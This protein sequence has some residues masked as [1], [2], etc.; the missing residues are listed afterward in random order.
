MYDYFLGG[1]HNFAIDREAAARVLAAEPDFAHFVRANREFLRRAVSF[2]V[3]SGV[4]QLLDL[5]SGIP[6]VGNV[7][8]VAQARDPSIRVVYV[9]IDPIAYSLSREILGDNPNAVAVHADAMDPEELLSLPD[10]QRMLDLRQPVAVLLVAFLHFVDDDKKASGLIGYLRDVLAPGS[11]LALTHATGVFNP[12]R[13]AN[14][15]TVY[16]RATSAVTLRSREQIAAF[17]EGFELVE[18]GIVPTPAWRPDARDATF[19]NEP[20]RGQA[21]AGVGR[22]RD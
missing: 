12:E 15:Q 5:G 8:E 13:A 21:F 9:D 3:G 16:N 1:Y 19:A 6:T 7:H 22:K 20:E 17:F 2:V 14:T 11:Y 10:V 18:P 4:R